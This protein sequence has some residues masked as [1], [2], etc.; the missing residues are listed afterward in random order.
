[1]PQKEQSVSVIH[2]FP[3][4]YNPPAKNVRRVLRAR[5]LSRFNKA[6]ILDIRWWDSGEG[7]TTFGVAIP[8]TESCMLQLQSLSMGV[9]EYARER[10]I[11]LEE[12]R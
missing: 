11:S 5:I 1:M 12:W 8:L 9:M 7:F 6:P 2:E 10:N 3:P 4:L